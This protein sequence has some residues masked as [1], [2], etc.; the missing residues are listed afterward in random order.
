MQ[1][2]KKPEKPDVKSLNVISNIAY[3]YANTLIS[4]RVANPA[5]VAQEVFFS[6]VI[7]E[8]AFISGFVM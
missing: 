1:K 7:P 6:V 2:E 8:T 3:R 4:S 5:D